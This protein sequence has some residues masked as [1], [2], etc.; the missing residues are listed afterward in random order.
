M[1]FCGDM[2]VS[3]RV[4]QQEIHLP[5]IDFQGDMLVFWG[6]IL[7]PLIWLL[8]STKSN[9]VLPS[10]VDPWSYHTIGWVD[11]KKHPPNHTLTIWLDDNGT[12]IFFAKF[13]HFP[14]PQTLNKFDAS[15]TIPKPPFTQ[16]E[17]I[18]LQ[19]AM[20]HEVG[21]ETPENRTK[22]VMCFKSYPPWN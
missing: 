1:P 6:V 13:C 16:R 21:E 10:D 12:P 20:Q 22:S 8:R 3:R 11:W 9:S 7:W 18:H 19:V 14:C 4:F 2:L 15:M 17:K 5:T